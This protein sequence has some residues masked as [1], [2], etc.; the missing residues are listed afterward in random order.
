MLEYLFWILYISE[1]IHLSYFYFAWANS[2]ILLIECEFMTRGRLS[3]MEKNEA[4]EDIEVV[5][6]LLG[7][8]FY[9]SLLFGFIFIVS[10][11]ICLYIFT[12][13]V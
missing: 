4:H 9:F 8:T 11:N 12:R 3:F 5:V 6:G 2:T 13:Y 1:Y 10:V 7:Y